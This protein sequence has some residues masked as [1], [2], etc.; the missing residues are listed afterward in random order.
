[1]YKLTTYEN[2][3]LDKELSDYFEDSFGTKEY[4]VLDQKFFVDLWDEDEDYGQD[5]VRICLPICKNGYLGMID[6]SLVFVTEDS[7][8]V[9]TDYD[10]TEEFVGDGR[11][12]ALVNAIDE[13]TDDQIEFLA[14]EWGVDPDK[15]FWD[16]DAPSLE[17]YYAQIC[18]T[19]DEYSGS[20]NDQEELIKSILII[21]NNQLANYY[22]GN[23]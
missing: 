16:M 7:I 9:E 5:E 1:M 14:D 6:Y 11:A 12:E 17:S 19:Y 8:F 4:E 13:L 22:S 21:F 23:H 20:N 3:T 2:E 18:N 10:Y 15:L